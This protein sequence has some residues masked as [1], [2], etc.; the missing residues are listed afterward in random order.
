MDWSP[1]AEELE[2]V[3]GLRSPAVAIAFCDAPPAGVERVERAAPSGCSYWRLA[4]AGAVF[5]TEAADHLGCPIGAHTHAVPL[6]PSQ[7]AELGRML[8]LMAG[9]DYVRAAEVP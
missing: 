8:E 7:A 1:L 6:G 5:Y 2:E 4:A 3:L 9:L